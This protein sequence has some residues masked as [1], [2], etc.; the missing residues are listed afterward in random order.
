[1]NAHE[2][3]AMLNGLHV[4][5]LS[6]DSRGVQA[7]DVFVAY[8]GHGGRTDGRKFIPDALARGAAGV[9]W[10]RAGFD[11]RNEWRVP[12][13]AVEG[14]KPLV[15]AIASEVYGFPSEALF[16]AGVTGTN[17][18]T[19]VSQWIAQAL[20]ACGK[21]C[22]VIGTLGVALAGSDT[23]F[24]GA[25][26]AANT[27]PDAIVLQRTLKDLNAAGAVAC[28]ME[29]SSI[30]LDQ[31]RVAGVA[32]DCAVFTNFTRDHL[33][34][35]ASMQAYEAAKTRLF[36]E[37]GLEHVVINLDDPMGIRLMAK[38]ADRLDRIAYCIE[39]RSPVAEFVEDEGRLTASDIR[40]D[41]QGARFTVTSPWGAAA[42]AA[43][44]W[45]EFNVSNLLAVIGTLIAAGVPFD[46]AAH[47]VQTIRAVPGR[48]NALGGVDAPLVVIDYA[49]TPDAL[50]KALA[51]LRP[52]A[53]ARQGALR[54][55]FGCGGDRD[56]GKRPLMGQ[57]A[58]RRADAVM[59][60]SDNPRFEA[61]EVI[62]A[63]IAAGMGKPHL[64][65]ADRAQAI[66][67]AVGGAGVHDLVLIAGKGHERYQ[68][69]GGRKLPFS[70]H[71]AA[72][73]ALQNRV[74][75]KR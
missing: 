30:G 67:R 25:G 69:I 18:K 57:V 15:G 17:G 40:F 43:P 45:G 6:A 24:P 37:P 13:V 63:A 14:L 55:V 71:D 46:A 10:E 49:H 72:R 39:G 9:L 2:I 36:L 22:G 51:T 41:E 52:L 20:Q 16:M 38:T 65:V 23:A 26:D 73:S 7:G 28:A 27:T 31:A 29:V 19:S 48:M 5:G 47:A 34:Y 11:W 3:L 75:A 74:E 61:P 21:P 59:L 54:V 44:V 50:E 62:I 64:V 70:D 56:P 33:D 42:I 53:D 12:N 4:G 68:D 66:A 8:P 35:H 60:T 32:F 58:E 1:V